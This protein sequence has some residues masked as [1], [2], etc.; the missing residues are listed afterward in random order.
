[1]V[2][3]LHQNHFIV[4]TVFNSWWV[5][6]EMARHIEWTLDVRR[7]ARWVTFVDVTGARV[8]VL[9]EA[10]YCVEQC[11]AEQRAAWRAIREAREEE[12]S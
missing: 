9:A 2:T 10:I 4:H 12:E 3:E 7:P 6:T 8:R 5:S 1:M 11:T